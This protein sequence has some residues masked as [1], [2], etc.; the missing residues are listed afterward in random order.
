MYLTVR[1]PYCRKAY[2]RLPA[3]PKAQYDIL[4]KSYSMREMTIKR[5]RLLRTLSLKG[6]E[7]LLDRVP[8]RLG[9]TLD[10]EDAKRV[11]RLMLYLDC[12]AEIVR[13]KRRH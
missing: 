1:C 5:I 7:R 4:L 8:T 11:L 12:Q 2:P 3:L 9:L 13:A 10:Y 6:A